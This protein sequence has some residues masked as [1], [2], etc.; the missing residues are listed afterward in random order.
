MAR[1]DTTVRYGFLLPVSGDEYSFREAPWNENVTGGNCYS[2][3]IG[4]YKASA[5]TKAMPGDIAML[6]DDMHEPYGL[7]QPL[8]LSS[9]TD[10]SKRIVA[11]G[12]AMRRILNGNENGGLFNQNDTVVKPGR[13]E[14]PAPAGHYKI[15]TVVDPN[16]FHLFRQDIMDVYNIYTYAFTSS[17]YIS[18]A[19]DSNRHANEADHTAFRRL[20][21]DFGPAYSNAEADLNRAITNVLIHVKRIP[22]YIIR[23][24]NFI[25]DPYWLLDC[26]AGQLAHSDSKLLRLQ[27]YFASRGK[28]LHA[29]TVA[30]AIRDAKILESE[31]R[32]TPKK[33]ELIGLWSQKLGFATPAINTDADRKLIFNPR[34]AAREFGSSGLAYRTICSTFYVERNH[35]TSSLPEVRVGVRSWT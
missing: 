32:K 14:N 30:D 23:K 25:L 27:T 5:R 1:R 6:F 16:D 19:Y 34:Y 13:E 4:H 21:P 8:D 3:A 35:G 29:A 17:Q 2:Y 15:M 7:L 24:G 12:I 10:L 18:D 33:H 31:P 26:S 22:E 28:R 20:C 9:C 11:D